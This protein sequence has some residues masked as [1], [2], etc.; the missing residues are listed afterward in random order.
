MRRLQGLRFFMLT[1]QQ[2]RPAI[3]VD[4]AS[5]LDTDRESDRDEGGE[6][7]RETRAH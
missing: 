6:Y 4:E 3:S 5:Q 2:V 1:D 7:G